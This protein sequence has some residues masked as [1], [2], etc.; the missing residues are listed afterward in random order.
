MSSKKSNSKTSITTDSAA[1][2]TPA[3]N[4]QNHY[5]DD[6]ADIDPRAI[7][8]PMV[9]K[10][11]AKIVSTFMYQDEDSGYMKICIDLELLD[12]PWTGHQLKKW[13]TLSSDRSECFLVREFRLLGFNVKDV[14]GVAA[15]LPYVENMD[16]SIVLRY[17]KGY[18]LIFFRERL[19]IPS[20]PVV[21][22]SAQKAP[23][24]KSVSSNSAKSKTTTSKPSSS[25]NK[26]THKAPGSVALSP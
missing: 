19:P 25:K 24:A 16:V 5:V 6:I 18:P 10:Y 3:D 21:K 15:V 8:T 11:D 1:V 23:P 9:G 26:P 2:T 22:Q 12:Q 13:Y 4:N 7:C 17:S 20:T 14:N